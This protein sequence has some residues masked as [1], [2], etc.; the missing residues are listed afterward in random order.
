MPAGKNHRALRNPAQLFKGSQKVFLT[1][2]RLSTITAPDLVHSNSR[3]H[4]EWA[5]STTEWALP[6][7]WLLRSSMNEN[8]AWIRRGFWTTYQFN[9]KSEWHLCSG[10]GHPLSMRRRAK[11]CYHETR[12]TTELCFAWP[13][14]QDLDLLKN[15]IVTAVCIWHAMMINTAF[16]H[17]K[18]SQ[19]DPANSQVTP[20]MFQIKVRRDSARLGAITLKGQVPAQRSRKRAKWLALSIPDPV[21]NV[22]KNSH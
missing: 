5:I 13:S 10:F 9:L 14:S 3:H 22:T 16:I 19:I 20:S 1:S 8:E 7:W 6:Q 18:L 17:K 4:F 2:G 11:Q 15:D 21:H 12:M